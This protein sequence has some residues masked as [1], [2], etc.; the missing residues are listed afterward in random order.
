M[1]S[2]IRLPAA[3][4]EVYNSPGKKIDAPSASPGYSILK[5][6]RTFGGATLLF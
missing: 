1:K 5:E 4:R 2:F 3:E 6:R